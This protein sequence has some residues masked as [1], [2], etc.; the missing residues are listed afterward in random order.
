[1]SVFQ[2][3]SSSDIIIV[4]KTQASGSS[5]RARMPHA[6]QTETRGTGFQSMSVASDDTLLTHHLS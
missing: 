2:D 6:R 1:M 4:E 3:I 5:Q